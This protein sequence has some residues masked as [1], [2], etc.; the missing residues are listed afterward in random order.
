[1]MNPTTDNRRR[2]APNARIELD[3]AMAFTAAR[4]LYIRTLRRALENARILR[5][6]AEAA[7]TTGRGKADST[8]RHRVADWCHRLERLLD[9]A[10]AF[11]PLADGVDV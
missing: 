3:P 2:K 1:M 11:R 7:Q 5:V 10:E 4:A 8:G 9:D 6:A